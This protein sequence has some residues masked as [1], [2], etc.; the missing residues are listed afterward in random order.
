MSGSIEAMPWIVIAKDTVCAAQW[1]TQSTPQIPI[2]GFS[3]QIPFQVYRKKLG[4]SKGIVFQWAA[5]SLHETLRQEQ[6]APSESQETAEVGSATPGPAGRGHLRVISNDSQF[7]LHR[8]A[9]QSVWCSVFGC[10]SEGTPGEEPDPGTLGSTEWGLW[11]CSTSSA[12][13]AE[14]RGICPT[15]TALWY[16]QCAP[17]LN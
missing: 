8:A 15:T 6:R 4:T 13:W 12:P 11:Q 17:W 1:M 16:L 9:V 2:Q 5:N 3:V 10:I 7:P 14:G